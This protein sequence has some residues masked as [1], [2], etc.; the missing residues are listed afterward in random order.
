M[1]DD[2]RAGV[3][4]IEME[5]GEEHSFFVLFLRVLGLLQIELPFPQCTAIPAKSEN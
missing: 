1:Q 5:K 4:V 3:H 2:G